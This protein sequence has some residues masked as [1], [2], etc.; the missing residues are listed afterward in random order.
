MRT[1]VN[2]GGNA[3]SWMRPGPLRSRPPAVL[4]ARRRFR[5]RPDVLEDRQMLATLPAGFTETQVATGLAAPTAMEFAPDGRLF[6]TQQGGQLRVIKDGQLL[7]TPF[8]S[9]TVDAAGERGLLGVAFDPQFATNQFVYVYYTVPG[10]PAHNRV[11]RFTAAGDVAVAG[12]ERAIL[13]LDPL[14]AA[15]NHNGGAIHFGIDGR[16]YVAA[17]ENANSANAQTASNLLGKVLRIN[18]DGSIPAD[19]P[20]IGTGRNRAIWA[21]GLRN[22]F[23]FA[24]QPGT[25]Q[26]F[27][28]D[29]G[30]SAWE[31]INRGVA[32]AN[33]GWPTTEGPTTDPRF[34]GPLFAYP[35]A[36]G[37][38]VQAIA[39]GAF[40]NPA[41]V[42]FPADNVGDYFFADLGAGWIHRL[43][44]ASGAVSDFATGIVAPVDMKVDTAGSLYYL[45]RGGGSDQFAQAGEEVTFSATTSGTAPLAYQWQRNGV[46]LPGAT[47]P[48]LTIAPVSA[49]DLGARFRVVV[50]NAFGSTVSRD[51]LLVGPS[52]YVQSLYDRVLF[53]PAERA[54]LAFHSLSLAQ[55][56]TPEQVATRLITSVERLELEVVR[57]Y[58]TL[59]G[60]T[61]ARSE[62]D[63]WVAFLGAG[64]SE[65]DLQAAVFGS[66]EYF[67]RQGSTAPG[68]VRGL[69]RD[70]LGRDAGQAE[71]D[72]WLSR[73]PGAGREGVARGILTSAEAWNNVVAALYV[74][75]LGRPSSPAERSFWVDQLRAGLTRERLEVIIL[76]SPEYRSRFPS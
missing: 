16:L 72:L 36:P 21:L 54:G 52:P 33:Y 30:Q 73:L 38:G 11:S 44:V 68:F 69:Y 3:M 13:D 64:R 37:S 49:G 15:T 46:D 18:A 2:A 51:A 17:G 76:S 8:V 62:I 40:Y 6:V 60:R 48:S 9:L 23:T 65:T 1:V 28:N 22:P 57:T 14:G 53:R 74:G 20:T 26:I 63:G 45:A 34:V 42:Q 71:V 58:R 59:L 35:H 29:V 12:S 19:N 27:I 25:G 5:P 70:I 47:G 75:H 4:A 39:G 7:P 55:G 50:S 32:G 66:A 56:A 61:P 43:D 31:E 41:T 24:V 67:G 10:S